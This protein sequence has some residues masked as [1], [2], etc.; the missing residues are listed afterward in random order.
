MSKFIFSESQVRQIIEK[1][2]QIAQSNNGVIPIANLEDAAAL[3]A[4]IAGYSSWKQYRK[5]QK[6][7][8][9]LLFQAEVEQDIKKDFNLSTVD[10]SAPGILELKKKLNDI[11]NK[12]SK[13]EM[14][15][16]KQLLYKVEVG[17]VYD[18]VTKA[19]KICYLNLENTC[20]I[21]ENLNFINI[22]TE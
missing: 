1:S 16:N 10:L 7:A 6:K 18:K 2:N 12:D 17:Q 20:F 11:S 8:G 3:A 5:E 14:R 15:E 13:P 21:G 22:C 19:T 4:Y 9:V